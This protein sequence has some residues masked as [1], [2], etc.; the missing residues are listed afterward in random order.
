MKTILQYHWCNISTSATGNLDQFFL[1]H[2]R[3]F[4]YCVAKST[5]RVAPEIT[6]R[7]FCEQSLGSA[8]K[9]RSIY[10][11]IDSLSFRNVAGPVRSWVEPRSE[12]L[13]RTVTR[14]NGDGLNIKAHVFFKYSDIHD[15]DMFLLVFQ[16]LLISLS[17]FFNIKWK[18][19]NETTE[20]YLEVYAW[21]KKT[22]IVLNNC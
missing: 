19:C 20:S 14:K 12:R 2:P 5:A 7:L 15:V 21:S 22:Y 1:S 6:N 3:A 8:G 4:F 9:V 13:C 16:A 10:C 11:I 18:N 17:R